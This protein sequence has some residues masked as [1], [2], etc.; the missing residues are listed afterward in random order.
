MLSQIG[1]T[2][3]TAVVI[4]F[5]ALIGSN[6]IT[7]IFSWIDHDR[8]TTKLNDVRS[9]RDSISLLID[10]TERQIDREHDS[11]AR[12]LEL[13]QKELKRYETENRMLVQTLDSVAE[14]IRRGDFDNDDRFEWIRTRYH[15]SGS[16]L[17]H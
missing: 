6:V 15:D 5:V 17:G 13:D 4:L 2:K 14:I 8:M 1:L 3:Q 16:D 12:L 10:M 11:I 7:G 9:E